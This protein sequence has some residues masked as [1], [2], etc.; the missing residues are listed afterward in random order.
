M[1]QPT[2]YP[3][4][5]ESMHNNKRYLLTKNVTPGTTFF[6]EYTHTENNIEYR[7]FAPN[8]SKVGAAIVKRI[9]LF[10]VNPGSSVLYLGASHGYTASYIS[11]IVGKNG[12]VFC[13]DFAPRVVRDLYFVCEARENMSPILAD[14]NKPESYKHLVEQVDVIIEDV[15]QKNQV[16]ILFKNLIYLKPK[17]YILFAVKARSIDVTKRPMQIYKEIE[18]QLEKKVHIIDKKDLSPLERDHQLYLCQKK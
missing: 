16:D 12:T 13:V 11:D 3:G 1:I 17:G 8:R 9:T 15:A 10:P 18:Q 7:E 2:K 6:H 14:A 5:Y 4:I